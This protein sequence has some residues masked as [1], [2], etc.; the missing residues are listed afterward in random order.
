MKPK[1]ILVVSPCVSDVRIL[2]EVI[3]DHVPRTTLLWCPDDVS[4]IALANDLSKPPDLL[5]VYVNS[6]CSDWVAVV[7]QIKS[8][9]RRLA[10]VSTLVI[11]TPDAP[12]D[13]LRPELAACFVKPF[14]IA[15][16]DALGRM[17]RRVLEQKSTRPL[18]LPEVF[19]SGSD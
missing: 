4:A 18:R 6:S 11:T 12:D 17:I 9:G 14:E 8:S 7:Q 2:C 5:L 10:G 15:G 16:W 13:V 1:R 19:P 3:G